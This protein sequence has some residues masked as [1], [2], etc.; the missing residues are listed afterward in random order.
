MGFWHIPS[1]LIKLTITMQSWSMRDGILTSAFLPFWVHP[2]QRMLDGKQFTI[3][4]LIN[5]DITR[6][7]LD[8]GSIINSG[9]LVTSCTFCNYINVFE[10]KGKENRKCFQKFLTTLF[11][12]LYRFFSY[13]L[14]S[15]LLFGISTRIILL[16]CVFQQYSTNLTTCSIRFFTSTH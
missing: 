3:Y 15:M 16:I 4:V 10:K 8:D 2:V 1:S 7:R 13:L 11:S 12:S 14:H 5:L 9:Q 6:Y